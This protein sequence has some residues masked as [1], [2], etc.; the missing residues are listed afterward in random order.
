MCGVVY[1]NKNHHM[2]CQFTFACDNVADVV[3]EPDMWDRAKKIAKAMLD[4]QLWLPEVGK[5]T[6]YHAY[7]VHPSWV[8]EMKKMYKFG[9]HTFYRPRAW[10]D[11]SDAPSWGTPAQTAEISAE[12]DRSRQEH[13]RAVGSHG[14]TLA[15]GPARYPGLRKP[16]GPP[17]PIRNAALQRMVSPDR[18]WD[19]HADALISCDH[20]RW[21]AR[22]ALEIFVIAGGI[23]GVHERD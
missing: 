20:L 9:V 23:E 3:R 16:S 15:R 18:G 10:G 6:H 8:S 5:S 7:W 14:A 1:Q 12:L 22:P 11:G 19:L 4:G 21:G 17:G 2:A 13:G